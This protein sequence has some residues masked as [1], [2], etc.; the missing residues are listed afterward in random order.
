AGAQASVIAAPAEW[1]SAVT[2]L[3]RRATLGLTDGD[4]SAAR[5]VGYQ[6]WLQ[7]QLDYQRIDSTA[8]DART[9][10]LWPTIDG[11]PDSLFTVA[12]STLQG[13]L[14]AAWTYR[15][16]LSPRQL[17]ERMVEFWSDHFNIDFTKVGY[18]KV[19]DDR[20]VIRKHALGR[21]SDLVTASS[22][23]PAM[24]AYLDQNVSRVGAPNQNYARELMELHTL[25]VNGGYTQDDVAELSRVLTGWTLQGRGTFVFNPALHDWGAKTVLGVTIP[26]G[27][28]ALGAAGIQEGEQVIDMLCNHP[29]TATFI[30]TKLLKWLLTPEPTAA[31]VRT[32]AGVFRATKGDLRLVVRA[33]LN[34][35]W[36]TTAPA[37]FKRPFHYLVSALRGAQATITTTAGTNNQLVALGQPLYAWETPDGY[38]DQFDYWSGNLMPRWQY[39]STLGGS[40]S[41]NVIVDTTPYLAGTP[42]AAVDLINRNFFG[43]EMDLGTRTA[44]LTYV[45]GGQFNE[46]RVR[47]TLSLAIASEAFQWY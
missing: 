22:K 24:L 30:S 2:R 27:S 19:I 35:G 36:V 29:S 45:K 12:L 38:P 23:S 10:A 4:V 37:K 11:T 46:S 26:A 13:S 42:D 6:N 17:Y 7:S 31:Q 14:Q 34:E 15:A 33:I 44:L 28:P 8:V 9:S 47:E 39:A 5:A 43:G 20:E 21:F 25:G 41:G 40:R 3:L 1:G 32:V 16:A 18:L